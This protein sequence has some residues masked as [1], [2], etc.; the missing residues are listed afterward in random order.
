VPPLDPDVRE[1]HP[2]TRIGEIKR[3]IESVFVL[4]WDKF[5]TTA[6][7]K[8][9]LSVS[10]KKLAKASLLA[11]K[12]EDA[13]MEIDNEIPADGTQLQELIQKEAMKLH[14]SMIKEEVSNQL[15]TKNGNSGHRA[16]AKKENI[17]KETRQQLHHSKTQMKYP[18]QSSR[19][20]QRAQQCRRKAA[21]RDSDSQSDK[22]KKRGS[23]S[24]S[25]LTKKK[26][27]SNNSSYSRS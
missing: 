19:T 17:G 20:C 22:A 25:R 10:L 5:L 24:K 8:K 7:R 12:T 26:T 4:L 14:K 2:T 15:R 6:V 9:Q 1:Q 11:A 3:A 23:R 27:G 13:T 18:D 21:V 16:L